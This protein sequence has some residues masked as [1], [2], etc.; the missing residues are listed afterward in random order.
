[1]RVADDQSAAFIG[2]HCIVKV[3]VKVV[4][5]EN[6]WP[7]PAAIGNSSKKVG[8]QAGCS[9]R[10]PAAPR[11]I[12]AGAV[13]EEA[14]DHAGVLPGVTT[15]DRKRAGL[16]A[17]PRPHQPGLGLACTFPEPPWAASKTAIT[18]TECHRMMQL[19]LIIN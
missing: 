3:K 13:G 17:A 10:S 2:I 5:R 4:E 18:D 11:T 12:G 15:E 6:G 7:Q 8:R 1:M 16:Q 9:A 14:G 19:H